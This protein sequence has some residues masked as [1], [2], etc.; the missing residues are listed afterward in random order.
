MYPN[1]FPEIKFIAP[2][3]MNRKVRNLIAQK[4][5]AWG[6]YRDRKLPARRTAYNNIRNRVTLEIRKAKRNYERG[7]ALDAKE[8]SKHFG[9][10]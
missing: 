1:L 4:R 3:W 5:A 2:K 6:R 9:H 7:V 10:M 8:N